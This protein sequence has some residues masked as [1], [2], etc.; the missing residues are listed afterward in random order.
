MQSGIA[1]NANWHCLTSREER[2]IEK[3]PQ[4]YK[5]IGSVITSQQEHGM[6]RPIAR[7]KPWL[8]VKA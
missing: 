6:I 3:A 1:D 4:A 5:P 7:F 2:K 8:M